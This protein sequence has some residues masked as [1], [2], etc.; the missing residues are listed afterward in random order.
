MGQREGQP[1]ALAP[2]AE[3][4]AAAKAAEAAGRRRPPAGPHLRR[5]AWRRLPLGGGGAARP[6]RARW[7]AK[8]SRNAAIAACD[9]GWTCSGLVKSKPQRN[10]SRRDCSKLTGR[11]STRD[12]VAVGIAL[13]PVGEGS[14]E[15]LA[16]RGKLACGSSIVWR[17][18]S[19]RSRRSVFSN[20]CQVAADLEHVARVGVEVGIAAGQ[21]GHQHRLAGR[22][23]EEG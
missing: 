2:A 11:R 13:E 9:G 3:P 22:E 10:V 15:R 20:G 6:G 16:G 1:A 19:A 18:Y 17:T 23:V 5:R 12:Q 4:A 8:R 7:A 21:G 14:L